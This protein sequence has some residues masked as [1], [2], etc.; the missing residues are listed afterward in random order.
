MFLIFFFQKK[1]YILI[2]ELERLKLEIGFRNDLFFRIDLE[3]EVV[4]EV[5]LLK[6]IFI[7][8]KGDN[9]QINIQLMYNDI[10]FCNFFMGFL[11]FVGEGK[12]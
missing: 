12:G 9:L 2:K 11:Y 7:K 4:E 1:L 5:C 8:K 10:M 6:K 3:I